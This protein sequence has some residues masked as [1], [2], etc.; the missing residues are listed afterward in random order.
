MNLPVIPAP[1]RFES[2]GDAFAFRTGATV[3][4]A[5]AGLAPVVERFCSDF[6][7][8]TGLRL[9]PGDVGA[10]DPG[11]RIALG[12][13]GEADPPPAPAGLSPV[14][15]DPPDERYALTVDVGGIVLRAAAAAG[16]ARGLT[17]LVQAGPTVAGGR[18]L[19]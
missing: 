1:A 7:R 10:R 6:V 14:G 18:I 11:V 5:G 3:A 2:G 12:P 13:A 19:D 16:I 15:D 4:F 17:T 9:E 8:R